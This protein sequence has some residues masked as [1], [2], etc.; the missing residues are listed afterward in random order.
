MAR[1]TR[2]RLR[3]EWRDFV[4]LVLVPGLAAILPW[5]WCFAIFKR[6][7][8]ISWLYRDACQKALHEAQARGQIPPEQQ[9]RWLAV[10]RLV[11]LV[12]HAD[13]YL[14]LTR[15][16]AFMHRH[17][18]VEGQWPDPAQAAV[19]LSFHWGAGMWAL[20]HASAHGMN[21]HALVAAMEGNP[22][23]GRTVLHR[24]IKARTSSVEKALKNKPLEISGSLRPVIQALR[25]QEQVLALVDVPADNV[26]SKIPVS[27]CGMPASTP[28][29]L[30]RL[31]V[32]MKIPAVLYINGFDVQTGQRDLR[33]VQL[34]PHETPE[35]LAHTLFGYL[36]ECMDR[37]NALWHF[38]G[39]SERFFRQ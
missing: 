6:L 34:P 29:G 25:R 26:E 7:S 28:K 17:L 39:E 23:A 9:N 4:E 19:C 37:E 27:L 3:T 30:L 5:R 18:R 35:A 21:I 10:R 14:A 8:H 22:F 11:M 2:A 20:R 12:D 32:D 24:Y 13:H 1:I 36:Q 38:W 16:D 33:I 31:A 15:S